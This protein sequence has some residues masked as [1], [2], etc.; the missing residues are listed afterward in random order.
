MIK[1][2]NFMARVQ[3]LNFFLSISIFLLSMDTVITT[4]NTTH[5]KSHNLSPDVN[6]VRECD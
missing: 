5:R 3:Y 4:R 1:V 6:Q 2:F